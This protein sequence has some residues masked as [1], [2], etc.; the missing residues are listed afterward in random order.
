MYGPER[1][2]RSRGVRASWSPPRITP[3]SFVIT[4][5][6][7]RARPTKSGARS[8]ARPDLHA[9]TN[10]RRHALMLITSVP[11]PRCA[12]RGV[13]VCT[14]RDQLCRLLDRHSGHL[15]LH[16]ARGG[17]HV[18]PAVLSMMRCTWLKVAHDRSTSG[19]MPV[20]ES[21]RQ[22]PAREGKAGLCQAALRPG[23]AAA[24]RRCEGLA[25]PRAPGRSK[26]QGPRLQVHN[27]G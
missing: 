10:S 2:S 24:I 26:L 4:S 9:L 17:A 1:P 12:S 8:A 18:L 7:L 15:A 11:L 19:N 23:K 5:P 20:P 16:C 25:R 27:G 13:H 22:P 6:A 14:L 3:G 21:C